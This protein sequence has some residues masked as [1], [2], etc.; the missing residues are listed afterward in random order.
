[1]ELL[2]VLVG[3]DPS[4]AP[5][6]RLLIER[7]E[8]NPFFLEESVRTLVEQA[9]LDGTPGAHRLTRTPAALLIP[10]TAQA[11]V[12]AR[13]D[14][15]EPADKQMLQA[16][17]VIGKD[18]LLPLLE[19]IGEIPESALRESLSR[20][21]AAEFL[22]ETRLFPEVEYSFKH[23]LTHEVTYGSV[24]QERRRGLHAYLV[25]A[26]EK[27]YSDRLAEHVERL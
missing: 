18:V 1:E 6:K 22:Y 15:L 8:G 10:A 3:T 24:L 25:D 26:I 5:L 14:R 13:I 16:A 27:L 7:T 11:I 23:A 4:L 9:V 12:A 20:L 19:A 2:D 17:S 21:Q